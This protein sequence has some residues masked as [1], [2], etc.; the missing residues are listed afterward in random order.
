MK[1]L[2]K[3]SAL[4][5]SVN[6]LFTTGNAIS[7]TI[8]INN[9]NTQPPQS[10]Q[11]ENTNTP[12]PAASAQNDPNVLPEGTYRYQNSDGSGQQIYTTGEKKPYI[13]DP[14]NNNNN[15]APPV[16]QPYVNYGT[17]TAPGPN[18]APGSRR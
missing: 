15:N 11:P 2:K 18:P 4:V 9:N 1:N 6:L 10:A 14:P 3:Y 5:I 8:N 17:G 13:V 7:E 16:V 12:P